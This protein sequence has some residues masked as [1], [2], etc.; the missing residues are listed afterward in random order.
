MP[1]ATCLACRAL[2]SHGDRFC[3]QCG[4][5]VAGP[6][7]SEP[8]ARKN[9]AIVFIDLVDSTVLA[10]KLD[11]EVLRDILGQYYQ[12]C[13]ES[14]ADHGGVI[15]KYIGDAV[16]AVFGVAV[17]REDDALR[18]V[19]AAWAAVTAVT[20]LSDFHAVAGVALSA[21]AG[22]SSGEVVVTLAPGANLRVVGD[23]VN[24]AARL[25]S[26]AGPGEILVNEEVAH[27]TQTSVDLERLPPLAL[28]GKAG[29]VP[30]WRVRSLSVAPRV[31]DRTPLA[32]RADEL[33]QLAAMFGEV[34]DTGSCRRV[35][36]TG[37]AGIGKSRLAREFVERLAAPVPTVLAGHCQAYGK[38]IT[39]QPL[40]TMLGGSLAMASSD[41]WEMILGTDQ[42]G[43]RAARVLATLLDEEASPLSRVART[44][45]GTEEIA[46]SVSQL[47]SV[48]ARHKPLVLVWDDVQ[49]AE[50][51]LVEL[52]ADLGV[53]LCAA[54]VLLVC[55]SRAEGDAGGTGQWDCRIRLGPLDGPEALKLAEALVARLAA[56]GW[57]DPAA[58][59]R[60]VARA[61]EGNALFAAMMADMLADAPLTTEL[62]PSVSAI[63]RARID[64]LPGPERLVLRMSATCG[65]HF[66]HAQL[67]AIGAAHGPSL[68]DLDDGLRGLLRNNLVRQVATGEYRFTETLIHDAAYAA[69]AKAQRARWHAILA[70]AT[71]DPLHH[72]EAACLLYRQVNPRH[73][74]LP[75]LLAKAVGQ[76]TADGTL[77]LHRKDLHAAVALLRRALDLAP[78]E[79]H[80][81]AVIV[82]RLSDTLLAA[83]DTQGAAGLLAGEDSAGT[84]G[85]YHRTIAIQRCIVLLRLGQLD[86][87][88]ARGHVEAFHAEL[89]AFPDEN[90]S[91]CLLHQLAGL[92]EL[93]L[94]WGAEA[95]A[96]LGNALSRAVVL[97]DRYTQDR[98]LGARCE[99]TQ[100]S[101]ATVR[102]SLHTCDELTQRFAADRLLLVP[103][104][105]TRSR[106]LALLGDWEAAEATLATARD[107]ATEMHAVL[108]DIAVTQATAVVRALAGEHADA[109]ALFGSA[110]GRL[111]AH[112]NELPARTLDVY[113]VRELLRDGQLDAAR[114]HLAPVLARATDHHLDVRARTWIQLI[115]SQ[116]ACESR[117][118]AV[119]AAITERILATIQTD[120]PCLLGDAWFEHAKLLRRAGQ[121]ARAAAAARRAEA[122]FLAKEATSP[123]R[124]VRRWAASA[125][126][127]KGDE[128]L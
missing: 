40:A 80:D 75:R 83:G 21:H 127:D 65:R 10:E 123:A 94:G 26:A 110:A 121:T 13:A 45:A 58:T 122:H 72:A 70:D 44:R 111:R 84:R 128:L 96:E 77:A 2:I 62:P 115:R 92:L 50:P 119:G 47:F 11:P 76:L 32:G 99:L 97:G 112:G 68:A 67:A 6:D 28:K 74:D 93:D 17:S 108:A 41:A 42:R 48:L 98:L 64:A 69:T 104:L 27:L 4:A 125:L 124:L 3:R 105:T 60:Q 78:A 100:W 35:L 114:A 46:W 88:A 102:T 120:D 54:P 25:Q 101:P 103:V 61:S 43:T 117:G 37:P 66:E 38:G 113:A 56:V 52:I 23:S 71:A 14:I 126:P 31:A 86:F 29:Y 7:Q 87:A 63:L 5:V 8:D 18:A 90:V 73:A 91:W 53:R 89:S 79:H 109:A 30:A 107:Y 15:E 118:P 59:A 20:A 81:R 39:Y 33:R 85:T 55:V 34:K 36:I 51:T 19:Q 16:M 22:V 9:V 12:A 49:W 95:E 24:T 116:I 82:V 106:L 57:P 1:E